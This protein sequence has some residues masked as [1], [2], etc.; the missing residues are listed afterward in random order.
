MMATPWSSN[1]ASTRSSTGSCRRRCASSDGVVSIKRAL[2]SVSD[3]NGLTTLASGLAELG[4]EIISTSGTAAFLGDAGVQVTTVEEL[5]GAPELLGGR[6]KTL[7]STLHAAILARRDHED[8]MRSLAAA[9]IEP[10]DLVVCNLYPFRSVAMRRGVPEPEVIAN[11]DI[12]GPTM[13]RA[14]A[15]NFHSVAVVTEPDRYG[16]LLDELRTRRATCRST[17]AATWPPR[18]SRTSRPTTRRSR[19]GS[20]TPSRSPSGSRSTCSRSPT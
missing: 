15:K 8:D 11:I 1:A 14:A 16:F 6:V 4:V 18:P 10:I 9:G 7:H 12:G 17:P 19:P 5:T 2:I 13:V 3:K 20:R